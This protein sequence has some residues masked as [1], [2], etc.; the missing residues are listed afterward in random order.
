M[1]SG[2]TSEKIKRL[3]NYL[4]ENKTNDD[5]QIIMTTE[6]C[7]GLY[8]LFIDCSKYQKILEERIDKAI[9]YIV[10]NREPV[11]ERDGKILFWLSDEFDE[12]DLLKILKGEENERK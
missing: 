5:L 2:I 7:H 8:E 4:E 1:N 6:C 11:D 3:F 10:T 12:E 9:E